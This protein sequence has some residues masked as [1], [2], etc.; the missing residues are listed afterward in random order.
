MIRIF[1]HNFSSGF[2]PAYVVAASVCLCLALLTFPAQG[3]PPLLRDQFGATGSLQDHLGSVQV[4]IVVSAKRL[5][6]IKR[7]EQAIRKHYAT[8]PLLRVADI[9]RTA[10]VEYDTV[11]AKLRKRLP[12]DV[13]VL[14]DLEGHWSKEY[15]LDTG[16]PNLLVFDPAGELAARHAGK[17]KSTGFEALRI[18]LDRLLQSQ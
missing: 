5:R 14:I 13:N 4:V 8:L 17:Y 6:R 7:W 18:D 3:R 16:V 2:R 11:A 1:Q 9:P 12:D 10:P 15:G